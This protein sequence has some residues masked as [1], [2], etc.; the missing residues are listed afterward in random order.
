V[1]EGGSV[2][3]TERAPSRVAPRYPHLADRS[4]E[5]DCRRLLGVRRQLL[6]AVA[7]AD[8]TVGFFAQRDRQALGKVAWYLREVLGETAYD[9]EFYRWR[10]DERDAN[11]GARCC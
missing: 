7:P 2:E 1:E 4:V 9:R 8:P 3:L 6:G 11:P 10:M 5:V